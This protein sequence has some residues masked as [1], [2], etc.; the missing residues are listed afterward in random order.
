MAVIQ[1]EVTLYLIPGDCLRVQGPASGTGGGKELDMLAVQETILEI[2]ATLL[3]LDRAG[4]W[5]GAREQI[6][7]RQ[8]IF[9]DSLLMRVSYCSK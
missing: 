3:G 4:V 2:S 7:S 9:L 6:L 8:S 1:S 5:A